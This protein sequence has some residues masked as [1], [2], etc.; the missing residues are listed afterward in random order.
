MADLSGDIP[1]R[2]LAM[3]CG[4]SVSHLSRAFRRSVGTPPHRRL[5]LQRIEHA[6][7]LL[8]DSRASLADIACTTG[9]SS[10]SHF[11]RCFS[12]RTGVTPGRWRRSVCG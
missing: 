4:L 12:A 8:R 1:L 5:L 6:K 9:F 7:R 10:Q 11:T 3:E 2:A